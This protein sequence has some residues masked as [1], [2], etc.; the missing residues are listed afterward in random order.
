M[1]IFYNHIIPII[2]VW[3]TNWLTQWMWIN[4]KK[5]IVPFLSLKINITIIVY[6][7][8]QMNYKPYFMHFNSL[9]I[10][11]ASRI[12]FLSPLTHSFYHLLYAPRMKCFMFQCA[13]KHFFYCFHFEMVTAI[14][15]CITSWCNCTIFIWYTDWL[16]DSALCAQCT[17]ID[18][19]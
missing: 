16:T 17:H 19:V 14:W 1:Q 4:N 12:R 10:N 11:Y 3:F 15:D 18:S 7:L 9:H 5:H 8:L 13:F 2:C 6:E